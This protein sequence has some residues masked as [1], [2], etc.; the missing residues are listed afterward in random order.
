MVGVVADHVSGEFAHSDAAALGMDSE[1][2][3]L[4]G[5]ECAEEVQVGF[6]EQT[7]ESERVVR[8][9]GGVVAEIR[10]EVLV[11]AC[12]CDAA[13]LDHL[14]IAPRGGD[15]IFGEVGEDLADGPFA[16]C[17]SGDEP[18]GGDDGDEFC[19][20]RRGLRQGC[21]R[22]FAFGMFTD[23]GEIVGGVGHWVKPRLTVYEPAQDGSSVPELGACTAPKSM[24]LIGCETEKTRKV[25]VLKLH[26]IVVSGM[27][28][29]GY[30]IE[31][32]AEHYERKTG[33]KLFPGTLNLRLE[34]PYSLPR[35][36]MR[37]EAEEYGGTVSVN[38]VP[39]S[40]FGRKGFILRTDANEE[41]RGHH[42]KTILEV[43][44]DVKLRDYFHL[45]DGDTVEIETAVE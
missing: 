15:F 6:A 7:I 32:L 27:G 44:T 3:P 45:C 10:P 33:M 43:A 30:W 16:G 22:V 34:T 40:V 23:A 26:G 18:V 39:C 25:M 9:A 38:I 17:R 19:N 31:K 36:V 24:E 1:A 35:K 37:L 41:E 42:P 11:E 28:N 13:V 20:E 2:V 5:G 14:S 8:V 12:E 4:P 21:E 29:F